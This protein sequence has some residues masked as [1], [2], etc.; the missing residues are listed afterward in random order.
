M[1]KQKIPAGF[2]EV[3]TNGRGEVVINHPDLKPNKDGVGHI[4]FSPDEAWNLAQLLAGKALEADR[5][6][7]PSK[8]V[9]GR[10]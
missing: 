3:G 7:G 2:L 5:E 4:V 1:R 8:P 6:R 10:K 9:R